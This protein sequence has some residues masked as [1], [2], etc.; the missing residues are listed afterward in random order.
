MK[1][2]YNCKNVWQEAT[3]CI[4]SK[5]PVCTSAI[6]KCHLPLTILLRQNIHKLA[7]YHLNSVMLLVA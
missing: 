2:Q 1:I 3:S 7:I 6:V 4:T 5:H